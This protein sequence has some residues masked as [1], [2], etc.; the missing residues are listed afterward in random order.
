[1]MTDYG[2]G[3]YYAGTYWD[4]NALVHCAAFQ[5]HSNGTF[6]FYLDGQW[7]DGGSYSL[8]QRQPSSYSVIFNVVNSAGSEQYNG[9]Y[10]YSGA[11]AGLIQMKN[12]PP[13]WE[14]IEYSLN[15]QC[16]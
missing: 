9:T 7:A 10:H 11:M 2:S 14:W 6:D 4:A 15:G 12:G 1:M 13:S 8:V 3:G 5:F 16:P